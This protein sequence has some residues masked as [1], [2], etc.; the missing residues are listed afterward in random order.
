MHRAAIN[1]GKKQEGTQQIAA[2]IAHMRSV[3]PCAH[4]WRAGHLAARLIAERCGDVQPLQPQQLA[5]LR[6]L[7]L[8]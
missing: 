7:L 1:S 2:A 3:K 8:C 4:L 6:A 5:S